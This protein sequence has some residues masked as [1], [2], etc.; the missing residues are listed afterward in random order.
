VYLQAR[1]GSLANRKLLENVLSLILNLPMEHVKKSSQKGVE[2]TFHDNMD[3]VEQSEIGKS[4]RFVQNALE[5]EKT[6]EAYK[7]ACKVRQ[8]W[9][10][11]IYKKSASYA[12]SADQMDEDDDAGPTNLP[13]ANRAWEK[14]PENVNSKGERAV[15]GDF[16][17]RFG[18]SVPRMMLVDFVKQPESKIVINGRVVDIEEA[19]DRAKDDKNEVRARLGKIG[20]ETIRGNNEG[21]NMRAKAPEL[22]RLIVG[23]V[24]SKVSSFGWTE[25]VEKHSLTKS[26]AAAAAA[27]ASNK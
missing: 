14:M 24:A 9:S 12:K 16:G 20:V 1:A 4:V 21:K 10:R 7:L 26:K 8:K 6:T 2:T 15:K 22:N 13:K 19:L 25:R 5:N 3:L 27:A 23:G 17:F 18:A 11:I